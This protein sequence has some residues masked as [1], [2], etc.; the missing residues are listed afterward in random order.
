MLGKI[1]YGVDEVVRETSKNNNSMLLFDNIEDYILP[2]IE[3]H[4]GKVALDK[5]R[6]AMIEHKVYN[7]EHEVKQLKDSKPI[8][9][10]V[11][12]MDVQ[13]AKKKVLEYTENNKIFDIEELHKNIRCDIKILIKIIDELKKEGKI[14]EDL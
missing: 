6:L 14:V 7:L 10:I 2:I 3:K 9:I 4:L 5:H 13:T 8:V 11:E 12:E 1:H